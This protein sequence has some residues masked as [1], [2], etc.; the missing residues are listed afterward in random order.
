MHYSTDYVFDGSGSNPWT[1]DDATGPLNI[2]GRT[3]LEG[4]MLIRA[5]G[6]NHLILR[7]SWVYAA[8]GHNFART[9]LRLAGERHELRVVDDQ[10]GSPMGAELLADVTGHALRLAMLRPELRGTYHVTASGE[11]TWF[12]FARHIIETARAAGKPILVAQEAICPVSSTAFRTAARRPLN[13]RLD[14]SRF[15]TTFGLALPHWKF[16]VN[17]MLTEILGR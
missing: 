10:H 5:S 11:T 14:T 15:R 12:E 16:G 8:R 7:T 3:K 13:S 17:R 9:M 4:E 1:E 6:C 2:Y